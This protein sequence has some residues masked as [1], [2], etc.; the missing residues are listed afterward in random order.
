[1]GT[2]RD[3]V[4]YWPMNE[5][6]GDYATDLARFKH[7]LIK[8]EW[9]IKPKGTAYD[10]KN[11][12]YLTL[13]DVNFVQITD[14]MDVTLS[15]WVKTADPKKAT[16]FSNGR[17]NG[18]DQLQ[19]NGK[20]N[21]WA[22]SLENGVLYLNSE[23]EKYKLS[24]SN[25][26]DNQWHHVSIVLRRIGALKT[27]IDAQLES[28]NPMNAIGGL[29]GNK[30]WIGARGFINTANVE[31]VDEIFTGKIDELRLWNTARATEQ[32]DRD[33]FNE[34]AFNSLGLMLY[35]R[36]NQPDPVS[37]NGPPTTIMWQQMKPFF[38]VMPSLTP[39]PP[40]IPLMHRRLSWKD[41][42]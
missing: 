24:T 4:G 29:S 9:D 21:K 25:L 42:T 34:V 17:G 30:F 26:A 10:L 36:M 7:A 38:Q 18:E 35:A 20:A 39:A 1:M 6:Y 41:H 15:F 8:A 13:D 3:L 28:S 19:S 12:Q 16:L 32:I 14:L 37:G 27:Y 2:E 40:L 5:G 22:V 23:G 33:R 11:N 31:T